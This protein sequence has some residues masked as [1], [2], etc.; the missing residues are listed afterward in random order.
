MSEELTLYVNS[1]ND[2][3]FLESFASAARILLEENNI[4][5]TIKQVDFKKSDQYHPSFLKMYVCYLFSKLKTTLEVL[6]ILFL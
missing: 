6:F 2:G 4:K 3:L 1:I 5:F